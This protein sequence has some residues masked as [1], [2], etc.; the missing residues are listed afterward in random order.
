VRTRATRIASRG[1]R[2]AVY[3]ASLTNNMAV[4]AVGVRSVTTLLTTLLT[5]PVAV[6]YWIAGIQRHQMRMS[7]TAGCA[8]IAVKR[9]LLLK[10]G[11]GG[12]E[13]Y[14]GACVSASLALR[15]EMS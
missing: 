15:E 13:G 4:L 3:V 11:E 6:G 7:F 5:P 14:M 2:S 12:K 1:C 10:S 8:C 9:R